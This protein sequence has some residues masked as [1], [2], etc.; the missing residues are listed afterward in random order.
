MPSWQR[1]LRGVLARAVSTPCFNCHRWLS[2]VHG[3]Q[4]DLLRESRTSKLA[5]HG[6]HSERKCLS[7]LL[8]TEV[9]EL[10]SENLH[11]ASV[12]ATFNTRVGK[13]IRGPL[14]KVK[15]SLG[16]LIKNDKKQ[17]KKVNLLS[18]LLAGA[19][20][21]PTAKEINIHFALTKRRDGHLPYPAKPS[22]ASTAERS[23]W[24]DEVICRL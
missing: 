6:F 17:E 8:H 7:L 2:C 19:G 3:L 22:R 4:A 10:Q 18:F 11:C 23:R 15:G 24:A 14:R 21:Q 9:S 5:G 20:T 1:A 12:Q 16:F 13:S